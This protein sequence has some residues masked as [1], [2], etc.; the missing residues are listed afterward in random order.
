MGREAP[1]LYDYMVGVK[2]MGVSMF[3]EEIKTN[4]LILERLSH[5]NVDLNTYYQ[6]CSV[7]E[8]GIDEVVEYIPGF[9]PH[10]TPKQTKD[11]VD[12]AEEEWKAGEKAEYII[13]PQKGESRAGDIAGGA[14]LSIEWE[15]QMADLGIWLR[16]PFW[17]RGY[18]EE[19]AAALMNMAFNELDLELVQAVC[20]NGNEKSKQAVE[21]YITSYGGTYEGLLRNWMVDG[22]GHPLDCHRFTISKKEYNETVD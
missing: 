6:A 12:H 7:D 18:S 21:K 16:K 20:V 4:R 14:R 3:P 22:N 11:F 2:K 9:E 10:R 19:R 8:P 17:G 1:S 13:R 15:K 5:E